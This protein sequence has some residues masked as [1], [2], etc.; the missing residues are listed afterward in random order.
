ML[1]DG[2]KTYFYDR[3]HHEILQKMLKTRRSWFLRMDAFKIM[4]KI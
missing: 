4:N 1:P 2:F 3:A